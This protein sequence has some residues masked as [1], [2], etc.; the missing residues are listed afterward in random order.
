MIGVAFRILAQSRIA[1]GTI[2]WGIE[3]YLAIEDT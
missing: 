3:I 1:I 2:N